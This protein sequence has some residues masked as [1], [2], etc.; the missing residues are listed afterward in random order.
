MGAWVNHFN[1]SGS[2]IF[3]AAKWHTK[4]KKNFKKINIFNNFLK[5]LIITLFILL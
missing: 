4:N 3:K 5:K 1:I 2:G